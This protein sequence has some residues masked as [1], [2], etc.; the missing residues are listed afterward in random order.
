LH[1]DFFCGGMIRYSPTPFIAAL[2]AVHSDVNRFLPWS[3][4]STKNHLNR[5]EKIPNL[6]RT[7]PALTFLIRVQ[8]FRDPHSREVPHVQI[9]RNMDPTRS[10]EMFSCSAIDIFEIRLSF[11]FRSWIWSIISRLITVLLSSGR[12]ASQVKKLPSLN[13]A[14][15]FLTVA[16]HGVCS[17]NVSFRMAWI[18]FGFLVAGET[19]LVDSSRLD[20]V[21]FAR[22]SWRASF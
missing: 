12:C 22:F 7:L 2:S 21:E 10:R 14:T 18:S 20:V 9:F 6:L 5:A 17:H 3:P 11:K 4:I 19:N 8:A 15:Q 1:W 16:Y 13:L